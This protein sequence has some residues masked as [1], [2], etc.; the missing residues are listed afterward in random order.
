MSAYQM[1]LPLPE[2]RLSDLSPFDRDLFFAICAAVD[3]ETGL[4]TS[5]FDVSVR[6]GLH[7]AYAVDRLHKL[8]VLRYVEVVE[9]R[10]GFPLKMR[11]LATGGPRGRN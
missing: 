11:P 4:A 3:P 6:S 1:R 5:L 10:P 8:E 7:T 9:R 2:F